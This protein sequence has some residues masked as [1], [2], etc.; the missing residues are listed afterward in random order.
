VG[1]QLL[2]NG[3]VPGAT[4]FNDNLMRQTI[5]QCTSGTRPA[6]PTEGMF[7]FETDTNRYSCYDGSAWETMG[8]TLTSTYTPALTAATTNPTLGGGSSALGRYT[9]FNGNWCT[10]R[11]TIQ[12]GTTGPNAGSGQYFISL[13][14]NANGS[15]TVGVPFQGSL[16]IRDSSAGDLR[17]GNVYAAA[18]AG[19]FSMIQTAIVTSAVPWTWAASDYISWTMT[20]ETQ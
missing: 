4:Y 16:A 19:T 14:F 9:L 12:F 13:P 18:N 10:V 2:A 3:D 5:V 7:V 11:G 1:Y 20:Y 17:E 8:Q 6:S 15:I